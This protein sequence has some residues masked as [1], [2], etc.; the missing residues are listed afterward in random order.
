MSVASLPI[1]FSRLTNRPIETNEYFTVLADAE[2]YA[3]SPIA[4]VGQLLKVVTG[5]PDEPAGLYQIQKDR[6]LI[7]LV[8]GEYTHPVTHP[9]SMITGLSPV[10]TSGS[11]NDLTETP[12][13][14]VNMVGTLTNSIN[15]NSIVFRPTAA[16][17]DTTFSTI[18][19]NSTNTTADKAIIR[20]VFTNLTSWKSRL[21][22]QDF[23][24][25]ISE[26]PGMWVVAY[27]MVMYNGAGVPIPPRMV[28]SHAIQV[29][30]GT[31][32]L[33]PEARLSDLLGERNYHPFSGLSS[34]G[35]AIFKGNIGISA[36]A[37]LTAIDG[38]EFF[39]RM[40]HPQA[41]EYLSKKTEK[42]LINQSQFDGLSE[43]TIASIPTG[44]L[45]TITE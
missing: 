38:C 17:F 3:L 34:T 12:E 16:A 21:L 27:S 15:L 43:P 39:F 22:V 14:S 6:S 26:G 7:Q 44:T 4:V 8:T 30:D 13:D 32:I 2:A 18:N 35:G 20:V 42:I 9:A 36:T 24:P 19:F 29:T 41:I 23:P 11:F 37:F 25:G 33:I 45:I 1:S 28:A 10:A 5:N 31:N 40:S